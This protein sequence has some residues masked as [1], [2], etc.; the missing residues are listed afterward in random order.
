MIIETTQMSDLNKMAEC[1]KSAFPN[2]LSSKMGNLFIKKMLSWYIVDQRGVL[3]YV[4]ENN[5]II[6]YCGG[7]II[8]KAGLPGAATSITQFC[9]KTF[10][11][12]F[13]LRPWLIFHSENVKRISFIKRNFFLKIGLVKNKNKNK[14]NNSQF[15]FQPSWGLVVI[16]VDS[17]FHG[18]GIGRVLLMEFERLAKIDKVQKVSLSVK[19]TNRQAI[20]AYENNGWI[21]GSQNDDSLYMYKNI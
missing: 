6:G 21:K 2:S 9:F 20:K 16:G 12:S 15:P 5:K 13:L 18:K 3:F 14:N 11:F 4:S 10:I 17:K 7:I 8:K 19:S 1:H